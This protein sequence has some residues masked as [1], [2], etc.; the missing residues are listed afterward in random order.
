MPIFRKSDYTFSL[1]QNHALASDSVSNFGLTT[2][3][4]NDDDDD[5]DA[6][7]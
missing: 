1:K 3:N 4:K 6:Q 5:D 2:S 7:F